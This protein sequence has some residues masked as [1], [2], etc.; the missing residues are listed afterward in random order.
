[1]L[2]VPITIGMNNH[3]HIIWQIKDDILIS[4]VQKDFLESMAKKIQSRFENL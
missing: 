4:E 3:I 1:M 2:I